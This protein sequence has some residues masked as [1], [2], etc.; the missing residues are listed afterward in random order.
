MPMQFTINIPDDV[1]ARVS[2][3]FCK[4]YGYLDQVPIAKDI[5]MPNPQ[6][7]EDFIRSKVEHHILDIV[8]AYEVDKAQKEAQKAALDNAPKGISVTG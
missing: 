1:A 4:L 3:A 8:K 5:T 7:K 2:E 6:S